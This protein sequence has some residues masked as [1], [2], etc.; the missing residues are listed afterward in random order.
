MEYYDTIDSRRVVSAVE[1]GY[2]R[3]LLPEGVPQQGETWEQI[4]RDIEAK[5]QPGLTHWYVPSIRDKRKKKSKSHIVKSSCLFFFLLRK[6]AV[7]KLHGLL[8]IQLLI[9]R[10]PRRALQRG[11]Q[12]ASFQLDLQPGCDGAGNDHDGLDGRSLRPARNL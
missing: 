6:K 2:L 4:Q 9:P 11:I 5:I 8:P 1:P 12:R 10:H 3:H 7:P